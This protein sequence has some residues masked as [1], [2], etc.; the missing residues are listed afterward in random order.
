M[1][2]DN[3]ASFGIAELAQRLIKPPHPGGASSLGPLTSGDALMNERNAV[4]PRCLLRLPRGR[5]SR[6][7]TAQKR[8]EVPS[9]HRQ[10]LTLQPGRKQFFRRRSAAPADVSPPQAPPEPEAKH[11][12][13]ET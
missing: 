2:D 11:R 4:L 9:P 3:I 10:S 7:R 6:C 5:P 8:D 12:Y 13:R 1:L